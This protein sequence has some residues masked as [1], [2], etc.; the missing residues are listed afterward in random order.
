MSTPSAASTSRRSVARW[1]VAA[2]ATGALVVSGSGLVAF[3]Q[4][5]AGESQGPAFVPA[6]AIA[7]VEARLD[8][9]GG[10]GEAL[11]E[12]MTAFPG[13]ADPGSFD[14]KVD[15]L[16]GGLSAEMGVAV[17]EG[18]LFGDVLTG[19]I[20][21]ALGDLESMMMGGDPSLLIGLA[22]ADAETASSVMEALIAGS[23]E[24]AVETTY[25]D[26]TIYTDDTSSPPMSV[27]MHGDWMIVGTG[28]AMVQSSIDVLDGVA[29]GLAEQEGFA[30]A[31]SRLPDAHLAAA[32]VDLGSLTS[33]LD[34]AMMMA[35]GQSGMAI[36]ELD[37]AAML[38]VDMA[39]SLAAENDR[40]HLE[41]FVTPGEQT[42]ALTVGESELAFA[43]PADTQ[44]YFE[45]RELG[46]TVEAALG[47]VA[48][49]LEA[50][51][52]EA[53]DDSMGLSDIEML[54][55]EDSPVT[56]LLGGVPL[57]EFLEF[58][59]DAA[60]GAGLSSD[61]LWL[62]IAGEVDDHDMAQDRLSSVMTV[63]RLALAS[64]ED[65]GVA[66]D[67]SEVAGVEVTTITLP[68]DMIMAE[69][70]LPISVGDSIDIAL[71]DD[72][73]LLGFGDFVEDAIAGD[74]ADSLGSS[75]GY[76]DAI[77]SDTVNNGVFYVDI[78]SLLT[79]LDPMLAMLAP[80]WEMVAPFAAGLD[81]LIVVGSE[82][83]EVL[84]TRV[85]VIAGQ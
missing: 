63:L 31:W 25:N 3:A 56:A 9:P 85:T 44:A 11:A 6:D 68:L 57:P 18:D 39:A 16:L 84:S 49:I 26:V 80:E 83:D 24:E 71:T 74:P 27:A 40:L 45:T 5:G 82:D 7:Y 64:S 22:L 47:Q 51:D 2:I 52:M 78:S 37:V 35:E 66:M 73:L 4:S 12:M 36:P 17:P 29:P 53:M 81:R 28:E 33:M 72:Q 60:V 13:F 75:E 15:E 38:P 69:T 67:T 14:M 76:I 48:T 59:G 61:G 79:S 65:M 10:Q 46:S 23:T 8:M 55:S 30:T 42:P 77:A 70:G 32:Y 21:L 34:M 1:T 19:E 50:Q 54:F 41:F 20:G 43:F 62:G 58:V